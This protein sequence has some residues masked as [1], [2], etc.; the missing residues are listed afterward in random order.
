MRGP[1]SERSRPG[2]IGA[3]PARAAAGVGHTVPAMPLVTFPRHLADLAVA[4]PDAPAVTDEDRTVDRWTIVSESAALA[5]ELRTLGVASGDFVTVALPNSIEFV[6]AFIA[7]WMVG[8]VPQ[9]V[10]VRLPDAELDA[11]VELADPSA[12]VGLEDAAVGCRPH[13]PL[14]FRADAADAGHLPD[15]VSRA[16]KAPTS[17]GS[18]GRPKLIV[19]GDPSTLD[20]DADPVLLIQR[21]GCLVMPGPLYH[22]GPLSW[23]LLS[24]LAGNHVVVTERF[25]AERTLSLI[26]EHRAN[27]VYVVPTMMKRISRLPDDVRDRYDLSTLRVVWHLAEP[28]P[29][30]LKQA[31]IDWLGPKRIWELYAGTENQASTVIR[32]DQWL[33]HRGSV[34]RVAAGEMAVFDADG[35]PVPPGEVGEIFMRRSPG[36]GPSYRYVGAEARTVGDGWESLGDMGSMDADGYLYLADRRTDM[37]LSGGANIYPAEIE[38]ALGEHPA[39]LSVAVIGLPDDDLGNRVHAVVQA[40]PG[41]VTD[42]EL[43]NHLATRLVRYKVPRSFEFVAE[44]LRDEAGK[45]RRTQLRADRLAA[46]PDPDP[47]GEPA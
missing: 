21:D 45:V 27:M 20:P 10:S 18:T 15:L 40:E 28:C 9:P 11:I 41:T 24:L 1:E 44:P 7:C 43:R 32:G 12:V 29:D 26:E 42:D 37:I 33:E 35:R 6:E 31:W 38:A 25:D 47:P 30:W 13:V 3:T 46:T 16:W 19:H 5:G 4:A 36:S 2:T 17:G 8:A 22:N 14:G 23:A 34:G 39:V